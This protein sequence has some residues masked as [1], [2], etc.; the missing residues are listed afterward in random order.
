MSLTK[1]IEKKKDSLLQL[2]KNN[3]IPRSLQIKCELTTSSAYIDDP[4][5]LTLKADLQHEVSTFIQKGSQI[6]AK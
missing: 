6:M 4:D 3:K 5:F 2:T 1:I